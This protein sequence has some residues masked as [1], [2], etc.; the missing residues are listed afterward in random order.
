MNKYMKQH[1]KKVQM[2]SS[3]IRMCKLRTPFSIIINPTA[4]LNFKKLMISGDKDT[5]QLSV[6]CM[7]GR[8][9]QGAN[10]LDN[11]GSS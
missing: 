4:C 10:T 1:F 6:P 7:A 3:A 5:E 8:L 9:L 11:G 2:T